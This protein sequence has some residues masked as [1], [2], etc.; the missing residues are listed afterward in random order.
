M[1]TF[2][3][4]VTKDLDEVFFN[5]DAKEFVRKHKV[6]GIRGPH[7]IVHEMDIIVDRELYHQRNIRDRAENISLN[8]LVFF[9]REAEWMSKFGRLPMVDGSAIKFDGEV[10]YIAAVSDN[11]FGMLEITLTTPT[12]NV[13]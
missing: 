8:G 5:F 11:G 2:Q 10:F 6:S 7:S 1:I 12:S 4:Q 13:E 3:D 9:V